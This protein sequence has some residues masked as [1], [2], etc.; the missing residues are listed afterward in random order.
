MIDADVE[1]YHFNRD[2]KDAF[3]KR[4]NAYKDYVSRGGYLIESDMDLYI[5]GWTMEA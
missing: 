1:R 3:E 4:L 2:H 5:E